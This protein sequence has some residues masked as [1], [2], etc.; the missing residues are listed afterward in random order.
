MYSPV[1]EALITTSNAETSWEGVMNVTGVDHT[2]QDTWLAVFPTGIARPA[3]LSNL[4]IATG[5]TIPNLVVVKLGTGG[6]KQGNVTTGVDQTR[7]A[8]T[9]AYL[10]GKRAAGLAVAS[11]LK[12][13]SASVA[14]A[15]QTTRTVACQGLSTTACSAQTVIV[16]VGSDLANIQ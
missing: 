4:N 7:T 10:P 11:T 8:T 12:L 14:P 1:N 13:G 6:F 2:G 15:D 16:T 5:Q 9:V 3:N